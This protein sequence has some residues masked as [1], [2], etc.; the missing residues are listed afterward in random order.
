METNKQAEAIILEAKN[1]GKGKSSS[2]RWEL[3][4]SYKGRLSGICSWGR[5][6]ESY[7]IKLTEALRI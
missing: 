1:R 5:E 3:Y 6:Y 2:Q 7:I 4:E